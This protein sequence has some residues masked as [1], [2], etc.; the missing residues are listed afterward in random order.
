MSDITPEQLSS[1][2]AD[3]VAR[4][5]EAAGAQFDAAVAGHPAAPAPG[6][7]TPPASPAPP[8]GV[9]PPASAATG[10]LWSEQQAA[11]AIADQRARGTSDADLRTA[12]RADGFTEEQV[13]AL[14]APAPADTRSDDERMFDRAGLGAAKREEYR[15]IDWYGRVPPGGD[16]F[17]LDADAKDFLV[18]I[19]APAVLGSSLIEEMYD[20]AKA[21]PPEGSARQLYKETQDQHLRDL[22]GAEASADVN[23]MIVALLNSAPLEYV[24]GMLRTGALY[25]ASV[26]YQL[27]N[28][29]DMRNVRAELKAGATLDGLAA[30]LLTQ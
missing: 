26:R 22:L 17:Q 28:I 11:A 20:A 6:A 2:R 1:A 16:I 5:G 10:P 25:S 7:T 27:A 14:L 19:E 23:G 9:N 18:S 12:L 13:Q 3:W 8:S 15:P 4:Y 30:A 29:A 21:F 24:E